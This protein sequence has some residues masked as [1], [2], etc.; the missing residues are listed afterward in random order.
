MQQPTRAD[1]Y[2]YTIS[3]A[4]DVI[5]YVGKGRGRRSALSSRRNATINALISFGGTL[6]PVKVREGMTEAEAFELEKAL[7]EFHGRADLGLGELLNS[8]TAEQEC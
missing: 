3:D 1:F 4:F 8:A 7:I 5:V 6:P 2:V